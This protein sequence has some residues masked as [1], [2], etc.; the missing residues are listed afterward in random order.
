MSDKTTPTPMPYI[1]TKVK[2]AVSRGIKSAYID[3][4]KNLIFVLTD[5]SEINVGNISAEASAINNA[6][7]KALDGMFRKCAF[8]GD[9]S[10]EYEAFRKAFEITTVEPDTPIVPDTPEVTLTGITATYS[11]GDVAVG[12]ALTDLTGITVTANYS[13]G[14][15]ANVTGYTLSGEIVEGSNTITV[16]YGGKTATFT[17]IGIVA[18]VTSLRG[19]QLPIVPHDFTTNENWQYSANSGNL[20]TAIG[21]ARYLYLGRVFTGTVYLRNVC[22]S[23]FS[24]NTAYMHLVAEDYITNQTAVAEKLTATEEIKQFDSKY[25][26]VVA[27]D[28]SYEYTTDTTGGNGIGF[29]RLQKFVIPEGKYAVISAPNGGET[30]NNTKNIDG[31]FTAFFENPIDNITITEVHE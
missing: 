11:G 29:V 17:V 22:H 25:L 16:S 13:D 14:S 18:E 6:Q 5:N 15:T 27:S 28:G 24:D 31:W 26:K 2:G 3:E 4:G 21:S 10:A 19:V 20:A 8:I 12:T 9:I 23:P 7:I 1:T 30:V